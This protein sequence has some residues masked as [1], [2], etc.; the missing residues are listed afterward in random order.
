MSVRTKDEI[1]A[2]IKAKFGEDTSDETIALIE[3]ISDTLDTVND[4]TDWKKKC[5]EIDQNWR[6]KSTSRFFESE[7][8]P[9]KAEESKADPEEDKAETITINDLFTESK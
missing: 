5:E 9:E 4:S 1:M 2:S 8:E 6:K 3:D 7:C